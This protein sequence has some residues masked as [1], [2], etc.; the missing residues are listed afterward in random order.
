MLDE[1]C[2]QFLKKCWLECC[3]LRQKERYR[4]I[5]IYKCNRKKH[6]I[7][8][9]TYI[10]MSMLALKEWFRAE[11]EVHVY[12]FLY[13]LLAATFF[14]LSRRVHPIICPLR[15]QYYLLVLK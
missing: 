4:D 9:H 2:I 5:Y 11:L 14:S 13:V 8:I 1:Q 10:C 3:L 15:L 12:M 7:D 6:N